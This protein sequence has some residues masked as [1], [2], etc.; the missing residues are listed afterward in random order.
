M[1]SN[2]YNI[3][4]NPI[5]LDVKNY[6]ILAPLLNSFRIHDNKEEI[7]DY[8][9]DNN[10]NNEFI[11]LLLTISNE[12]KSKISDSVNLELKLTK[13]DFFHKNLLEICVHFDKLEDSFL[14]DD[15]INRLYDKFSY[16]LLDS[17][18]WFMEF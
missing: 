16:A 7:N 6:N 2:S 13:G 3:Y 10:L 4:K 12:I 18:S 11:N 15:I 5:Q 9:A 14:L 1:L 17:I 8:I